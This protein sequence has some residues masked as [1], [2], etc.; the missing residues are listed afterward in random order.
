MTDTIHQTYPR[1]ALLQAAAASALVQLAAMPAAAQASRPAS[2]PPRTPGKPGDFDFLS[3]QWKIHNRQR[4]AG[5]KDWDEFPG[6]ATVWS[7]L[8]GVCS[9]EELRIPARNF[10]GMGLRVLDMDKRVWS[11]YWMNAKSGVLGS[12]GT[13]GSFENGAGIFISHDTEDGKPVQYRGLW[14]GI[15]ATSC[16]WSQ[17]VSRDGGKTWDDNWRMQWTRV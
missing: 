8:G 6:E 10:S 1:R 7:I 2:P 9:I 3:G 16:R 15:T 13:P 5:Q 17:A 4:K 11:D 14:D 12:E